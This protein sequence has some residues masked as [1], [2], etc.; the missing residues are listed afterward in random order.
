MALGAVPFHAAVPYETGFHDVRFR[1]SWKRQRRQ[2]FL[3]ENEYFYPELAK[4]DSYWLDKTS[5]QYESSQCNTVM[6]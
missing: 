5:I 3:Q 4:K 6:K 2:Y 1:E